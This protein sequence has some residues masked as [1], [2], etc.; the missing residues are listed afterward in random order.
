MHNSLLLIAT[1]LLAGCADPEPGAVVETVALVDAEAWVLLEGD[2]DPW[3]DGDP[4]ADCSVYGYGAE[5][6]HFEVETELCAY[7]TFAQPSLH[8][9]S[10]GDTLSV[11]VWHVDLF[12]EDPD[13]EGHVAV[14]IDGDTLLEQTI[15]IPAEAEVY[16]VVEAA[17][18]D[19]AKGEIIHFHVH[20]HGSNA[21]AIGA[22][23]AETLP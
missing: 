17:P 7:G 19:M 23:E 4:E 22:V 10:K 21:W 2:D 15:P 12:S 13:A 11:V 3:Q 16:E 1:A 18:R 14:T 20:N 5:G 8:A 6:S 9:V